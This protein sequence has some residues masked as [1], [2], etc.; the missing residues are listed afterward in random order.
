[1]FSFN[2]D[3]LLVLEQHLL[4]TCN[5]TYFRK[6]LPCYYLLLLLILFFLTAKTLSHLLFF[7]ETS[8][9]A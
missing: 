1:M 8:L 2:V 3:T 4:D 7:T 9:F 5:D 6:M